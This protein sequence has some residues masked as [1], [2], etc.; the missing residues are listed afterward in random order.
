MTPLILVSATV[1]RFKSSSST[2]NQICWTISSMWVCAFPAV[3]CFFGGHCL[4]ELSCHVLGHL[5]IR[6]V[7]VL[8]WCD[9]QCLHAMHC[10]APLDPMVWFS[11][12]MVALIPFLLKAQHEIR[13][14]MTKYLMMLGLKIKIMSFAG[15]YLHDTVVN[16]RTL[17]EGTTSAND[18]KRE[19][20]CIF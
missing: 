13:V 1:L 20:R 17:S 14:S 11:L 5:V 8:P 4:N 16:A 19:S 7:I 18:S 6:S 9:S 12:V 10:H 15:R 2:K 3:L